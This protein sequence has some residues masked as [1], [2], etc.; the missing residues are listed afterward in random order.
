MKKQIYRRSYQNVFLLFA[1]AIFAT[2]SVVVMPK[3][4]IGMF[5]W[6]GT[7]STIGL[8]SDS[9]FRFNNISASRVCIAMNISTYSFF[10]HFVFTNLILIRFNFIVNL[11]RNAI[12][13]QKGDVNQL[14]RA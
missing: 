1:M 9:Q 3:G 4:H 12:I 6:L 5:T 10:H 2:V 8:N 14:E 7:T 13:K 11:F